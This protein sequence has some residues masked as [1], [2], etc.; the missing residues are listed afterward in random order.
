MKTFLTK[1]VS[2]AMTSEVLVVHPN[3]LLSRLQ[4]HFERYR[5]NGLPV[6]NDGKLVGWVTQFDLL[7]AFVT[8]AEA[9]ESPYEEL[10]AQPTENIMSVDP[11]SVPPDLTL[12]AVLRR[13]IETRHRSFPVTA[14]G[15]LLGV[16]ARE[17]I[18]NGL[19]KTLGGK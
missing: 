17:D 1:T 10:L 7:N 9:P 19:R 16:I 3:S 18:I 13:M 5:F 15:K 4:E 12:A 8:A 6:V 11:E 14:E 2:E